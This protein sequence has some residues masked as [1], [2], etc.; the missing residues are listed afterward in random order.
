MRARRWIPPAATRS[1]IW[2]RRPRADGSGR[3]GA[4][5]RASGAAEWHV[6]AVNAAMA[7]LCNLA[8]RI[9]RVGILRGHNP[10]HGADTNAEVGGKA[11]NALSLGSRHPD[12]CLRLGRYGRPAQLFA[13]CPRPGEPS[14]NPLLNHGP[15]E[16]RE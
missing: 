2:C 1:K 6:R 13:F 11:A 8:R 15:L 9:S 16:F 7:V 4:D 3:P 12:S 14:S 5:R 10:I